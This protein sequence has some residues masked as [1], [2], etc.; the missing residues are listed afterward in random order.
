M[1]NGAGS[2]FYHRYHDNS[3]E[4]QGLAVAVDEN[5]TARR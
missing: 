1:K 4:P 2:R 5:A 3:L